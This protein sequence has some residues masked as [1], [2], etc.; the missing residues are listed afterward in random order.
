MGSSRSQLAQRYTICAHIVYHIYSRNSIT[1]MSFVTSKQCYRTIQIK[2]LLRSLRYL[3]DFLMHV[4]ILIISLLLFKD[5]ISIDHM[6]VDNRYRIS[7]MELR[8]SLLGY[9]LFGYDLKRTRTQGKLLF[10][11]FYSMHYAS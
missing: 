3:V 5:V 7:S 1:F 11:L 6:M 4:T 9:N 10:V 8:G 2:Y